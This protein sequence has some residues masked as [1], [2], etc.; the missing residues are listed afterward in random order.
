MSPTRSNK[1]RPFL[2]NA[3]GFTLGQLLASLVIINLVSFFGYAFLA[4]LQ[5]A[6]SYAR[7]S[8]CYTNLKHVSLAILQYAA[9]YDERF[10]PCAT[11]TKNDNALLGWA[12]THDRYGEPISLETIAPQ[13]TFHQ[14]IGGYLKTESILRCPEV[15]NNSGVVAYMFNDLAAGVAEKDFTAPQNTVLV[16]DGEN[17]AGNV[18]HAYNPSLPPS[19]ASFFSDGTV[20]TGAVLQKAP[21]RHNGRATYGFADGHVKPRRSE[22]H[23][24]STAPIRQPLSHRQIHRQHDWP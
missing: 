21:T 12:A 23:L 14:L 1:T 4:V 16:C 22:S 10:P 8:Q 3:S 6:N 24:F 17:F 5:Q 13:I 2:I 9:D 20:V 19:P 18:G 15:A 11:A 7:R